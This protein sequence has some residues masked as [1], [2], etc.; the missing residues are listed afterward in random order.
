MSDKEKTVAST[1]DVKEAAPSAERAQA[2]LKKPDKTKEE[3][4]KL[5]QQEEENREN[6]K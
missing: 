4:E 1:L 5:L 6:S 2:D 3:F